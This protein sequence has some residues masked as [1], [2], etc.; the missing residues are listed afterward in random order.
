MNEN[1]SVEEKDYSMPEI[2]EF[3]ICEPDIAKSL[4]DYR[5]IIEDKVGRVFE[6][7]VPLNYA[8]KKTDLGEMYF[9]IAEI[10]ETQVV[11]AKI[12]ERLNDSLCS[13]VT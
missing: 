13:Y 12:E 9:F 7:F 1:K 10:D 8:I 2:D 3:E 4:A 5:P 6:K 11:L